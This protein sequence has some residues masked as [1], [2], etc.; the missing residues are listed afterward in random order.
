MVGRV[1]ITLSFVLFEALRFSNYCGLFLQGGSDDIRRLTTIRIFDFAVLEGIQS[2][3]VRSR[4][5]G[6]DDIR[7]LTTLRIFDF[8][9]LAGIQSLIVLSRVGGAGLFCCVNMSR[10]CRS[11]YFILVADP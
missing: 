10:P 2:F 1:R 7:H 9:V 6:S 4:V 5:G 3:I 8:A 11:W